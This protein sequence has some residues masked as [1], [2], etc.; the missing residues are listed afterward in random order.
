PPRGVRRD[1]GADGGQ[2]RRLPRGA[3]GQ[4]G[5]GPLSAAGSLG[6]WGQ[7]ESLRRLLAG[8]P[9]GGAQRTLLFSGP[10]GVGRRRAAAWLCAYLNCLAPEGSRPCGEC[11]SCSAA[12]A[13]SSLDY[14]EVA[15]AATSKTG[16]AKLRGEIGIDRLVPR[17]EPGSDPEP[18]GPWLAARP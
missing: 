9:P 14:K 17:D 5:G 8:A 15:P 2:G 11:A 6:A 18:L 4:A 7:E 1:G 12:L 13:G 16:R 10:D 3:G